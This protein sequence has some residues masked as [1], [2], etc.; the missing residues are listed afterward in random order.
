VDVYRKYYGI[1]MTLYLFAVFFVTMVVTAIIMDGAFS[2]LHLVPT[3]NRNIVHDVTMFSFNYTFWLNLAFGALA[4][5]MWR[6]DA[7][8]P[9][10]HG[11][12]AAHEEHA[13]S[14]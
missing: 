5:Y 10:D 14:G 11:C 3:P 13:H 6:L 1:R 9:M 8:H 7:Q 12:H 2:A 4:L